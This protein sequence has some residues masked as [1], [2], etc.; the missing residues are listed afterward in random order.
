MTRNK[1]LLEYLEN[2]YQN[3]NNKRLKIEEN[4]N[5]LKIIENI[6]NEVINLIN[7]NN[8]NIFL[9]NYDG[10]DYGTT[11]K[12]H[13]YRHL[14]KH[15]DNK[16]YKCDNCSFSTTDSC[17]ISQHVE[18]HDRTFLNCPHCGIKLNTLNQLEKHID[19]HPSTNLQCQFYKCNESRYGNYE[20][21]IHFSTHFGKNN[22]LLCPLPGCHYSTPKESS[23]KKHIDNHNNPIS[24]HCPENSCN[25]QIPSKPLMITHLSDHYKKLHKCTYL[26][27][28]FESDNPEIL[29]KHRLIHEKIYQCQN[30]GCNYSAQQP[31]QIKNHQI[32]HTNI[33]PFKCDIPNCNYSGT[34][35]YN[36][37]LHLKTHQ[38]KILSH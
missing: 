3:N 38:K 22:H 13:Y 37:S 14:T 7:T 5:N 9:C 31:S 36:L 21:V 20:Y 26:N 25:Y 35:K 17:Y 23:I 18:S 10:C 19:E 4:N 32:I 2:E 24:I 16:P 11:R 8:N 1:R 29:A 33:K 12:D 6:K 15:I 30:P 34:R 27:C 28:N